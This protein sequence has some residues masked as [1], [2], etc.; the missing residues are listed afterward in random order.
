MGV[1]QQSPTDELQLRSQLWTQTIKK[2]L[3][4]GTWKSSQKAPQ[5]PLLNQCFSQSPPDLERGL[6][7]FQDPNNTADHTAD[8]MGRI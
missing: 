3:R 1:T 8:S 6:K 2:K 4:G 7:G 5:L